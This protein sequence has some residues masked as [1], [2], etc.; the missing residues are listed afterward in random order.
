MLFVTLYANIG[1][2]RRLCIDGLLCV[3]HSFFEPA[4][5]RIDNALS[6]CIEIL[7]CE[8]RIQY[9]G[10]YRVSAGSTFAWTFRGKP[11]VLSP[12][13]NHSNK[14]VQTNLQWSRFN[15]ACSNLA[16]NASVPRSRCAS[17]RNVG[18]D[19]EPQMV[20][21]PQQIQREW[22]RSCN[23]PNFCVYRTEI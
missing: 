3:H 6:T 17:R 20:R 7:R 21:N 15:D 12:L 1:N 9:K 23:I 19:I 8:P 2:D 10:F 13:G 22:Y 4:A 16:N 11:R 18:D 14:R 5:R